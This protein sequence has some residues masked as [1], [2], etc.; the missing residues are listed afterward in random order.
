MPSKRSK[1]SFGATPNEFWVVEVKWRPNEPW[2]PRVGAPTEEEAERLVAGW[3][4]QTFWAKF[5]KRKYVNA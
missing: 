2:F 3:E 5:R 4:A 1:D